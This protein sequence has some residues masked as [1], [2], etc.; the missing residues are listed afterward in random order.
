MLCDLSKVNMVKKTSLS[1]NGIKIPVKI[2]ME[3]RKTVRYSINKKSISVLLPKFFTKDQIV[4]EYYKLKSWCEKQFENDPTLIDRFVSLEYKNNQ[5][6]K[7]YGEEFKLKIESENRKT[8]GAEF[9]DKNTILIKCPID[10]DFNTKNRLIG[11]VLSRV[12]SNY[13][14]P[15]V[16]SRVLKLNDIHFKEEIESIRLKNNQSNWGSCSSKRNINLSSRL[17]MAPQD[18]FDYVIIHELAHLKEMNHS[19]RFWKIV[20][21][22]MPEYKEKERWLTLH[23]NTLKF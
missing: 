21:K 19:P 15:K 8:C 3:W 5:I 4:N 2:K 17:L 13:F 18:V 10:L 7:I 14:L 16:E 22:A 9:I 11:M 6:Y 1:I 20:E 12:F 23:G